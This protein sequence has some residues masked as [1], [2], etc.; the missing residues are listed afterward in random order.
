M[1]LYIDGYIIALVIII[2]DLIVNGII[3]IMKKSI[4]MYPIVTRIIF[5]PLGIF[6]RFVSAFFIRDKKP[7]EG[8]LAILASISCFAF[9]L[10]LI[11]FVALPYLPAELTDIIIPYTLIAIIAGMI[12]L[13]IYYSILKQ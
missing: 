8:K 6:Q 5:A 13:I 2:I 12:V 10:M 7:E 1:A 3:G 4:N 11:E 9:A